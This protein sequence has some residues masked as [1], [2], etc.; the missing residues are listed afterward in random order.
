MRSV[1]RLDQ[2]EISV[3]L[4]DFGYHGSSQDVLGLIHKRLFITRESTI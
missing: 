1:K 4:K 3:D 2:K